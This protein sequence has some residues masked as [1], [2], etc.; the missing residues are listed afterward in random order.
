MHFENTIA[1]V[2]SENSSIS[3]PLPFTPPIRTT[4]SLSY[5]W[6]LNTKS[7]ARV[8]L[9]AVNNFAQNRIDVFETVTDGYWVWNT[10]AGI[11]FKNGRHTAMIFLRCDNMLNKQYFN[12]MSRYKEIGVMGFGRN[13]SA[14]I[15]FPFSILNH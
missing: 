5:D 10:I 14:G 12:N 1:L 15:Q 11:D 9:E 13:I 3:T 6:N 7:T 2:I 4:H 8:T